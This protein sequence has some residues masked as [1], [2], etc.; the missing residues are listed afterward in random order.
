M[1]YGGSLTFEWVILY[2]RRVLEETGGTFSAS[3][4]C[5]R[6]G[7]G[8]AARARNRRRVRKFVLKNR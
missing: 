4:G 8:V 1:T 7:A 5:A 6:A 2:I 3:Y